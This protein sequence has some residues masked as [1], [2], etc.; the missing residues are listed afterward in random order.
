[1]QTRNSV[2]IGFTMVEAAVAIALTAVAGAAVLVGVSS[3]IDATSDV[4]HQTIADG[5][6]QQLVDE[7]VGATYGAP[8]SGAYQIGFGPNSWEAAGT[9]RSRFNDID[10]YHG[11][12]AQPP[13][14]PQGIGLGNEDGLGGV[15]HE[16]FRAPDSFFSRWRQNA[17]VYYVSPANFSQRLPSSNTSD[18]RC[19]EVTIEYQDPMR[20]WLTIAQMKRVVT[21]LQ[22]P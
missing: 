5:M 19:V 15:R 11:V 10:D 4:V 14:G 9:G 16:N 12:L 1:M 17:I 21:Y 6:A 20:G 22:V 3:S 7:I 18:Y 13:T 8:G 2:R